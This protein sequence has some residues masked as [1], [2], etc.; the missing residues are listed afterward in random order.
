MIIELPKKMGVFFYKSAFPEMKYTK[1]GKKTDE[2]TVQPA[3]GLPI[4]KVKVELT[5]DGKVADEMFVSVPLERNPAEGLRLNEEVAFEGLKAVSGVRGSGGRW[6]K[7]TATGIKR[8]AAAN[9]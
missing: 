1:D 3:T 5:Q 9:G 7:F 4:W 6:L 2:Q 8:R